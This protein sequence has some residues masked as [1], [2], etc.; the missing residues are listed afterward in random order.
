MME[1]I[2]A[3]FVA[4]LLGSTHC[5]GMCGAF[6]AIAVTGEAGPGR[7][8]LHAAYNVG[9]LTTY[10]TLGAIAG[11]IGAAVDLGGAAVGVQRAATVAAGA[12]MVVIGLAALLRLCGVRVPKPPVPGLMRRLA[13]RGHRGVMSWQPLSR[14]GAIGLLTT[15]LPCGWLYAFV[16][17]AAGTGGPLS[18]AATMAVFWLGTLPMM[19][20]LGIGVQQLAG[21]FR[22]KLPIVASIVIVGVGVMT[23]LGRTTM[24]LPSP[25][26]VRVSGEPDAMI[27]R[28]R[29]LKAEESSCCD[30]N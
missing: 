10:T 15:L 27:E 9:R 3:V 7:A 2:A 23:V 4:S 11:A 17:T 5:A 6:V 13:V 30:G 18:G 8:W 28:V 25:S 24:Q 26:G 1:L 21:S 20:A 14:A 19:L 16:I 29:G 22:G 12:I